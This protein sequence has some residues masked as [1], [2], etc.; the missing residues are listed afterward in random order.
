[1][2]FNIIVIFLFL[3]LLILGSNIIPLH[4][5]LNIQEKGEENMGRENVIKN[6]IQDDINDKEIKNNGYINEVIGIKNKGYVE[7]DNLLLDYHPK[8]ERSGCKLSKDLPIANV[9]IEHLF[10]NGSYISKL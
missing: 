4:E 8:L 5:S 2:N 3:L 1:M 10:E 9:K 7:F 6:V